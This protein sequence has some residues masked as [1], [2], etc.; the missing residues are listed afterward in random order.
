[1]AS[2]GGTWQVLVP[3]KTLSRAKTRL[4]LPPKDRAELATAMLRDTLRAVR[5]TRLVSATH[6]ITTDVSVGLVTRSERVAAWTVVGAVGLNDEVRQAAARLVQTGTPDG[7][8][9]VLGDL[10]C[11]TAVVLAEVLEAA[12]SDGQSFLVDAA[13]TGTTIL[14]A[15]FGVGFEP[16]FEFGS[17]VRHAAVGHPLDGPFHWRS[18]RRDVDTLADLREAEALGLGSCTRAWVENRGRRLGSPGA[19][20]D[21]AG[22][23]GLGRPF[24]EMAGS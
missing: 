11:L 4:A 7:I 21:R 17:A 24:I 15:P 9:V 2:Q 6:V 10:P 12:P 16:A 23:L 1:M 20:A 19:D 3:V 8:V 22:D 14:I 18:A 13:G 5:A